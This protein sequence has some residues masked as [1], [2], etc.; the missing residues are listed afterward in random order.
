[1]SDTPEVLEAETIPVVINGNTYNFTDIVEVGK[2]TEKTP[3]PKSTTRLEPVVESNAQRGTFLADLLDAAEEKKAGEGEKLWQRLFKKYFVSCTDAVTNDRGEI[4]QDGFAEALIV[5][6]HGAISEDTVN[7]LRATVQA[8]MEPLME[9]MV[10]SMAE[11]KAPYFAKLKEL[12]FEDEDSYVARVLN[13][14]NRLKDV[15]AAQDKL[16]AAKLARDANRARKQKE[17]AEK[18]AATAAK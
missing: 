5:T 2:K 16:D 10:L 1:M 8:E 3:N 14:Q 18:A 4:N 13:C 12:G 7:E 11:D 9:V 6:R 15:K 17:A